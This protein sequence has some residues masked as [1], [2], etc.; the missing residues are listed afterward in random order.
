MRKIKVSEEEI[1]FLEEKEVISLF[2]NLPQTGVS[3]KVVNS[4]G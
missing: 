4:Y 2:D 1:E 3:K